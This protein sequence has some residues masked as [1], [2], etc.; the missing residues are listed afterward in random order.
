MVPLLKLSVKN[1]VG[2]D[3]GPAS[4]GAERAVKKAFAIA[5]PIGLLFAEHAALA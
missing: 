5:I 2:S 1:V 4:R 3:E